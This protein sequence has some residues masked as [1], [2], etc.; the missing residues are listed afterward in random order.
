MYQRR[1]EELLC[2][3]IGSGPPDARECAKLVIVLGLALG[4][5]PIQQHKTTSLICRH[6]TFPAVRIFGQSCVLTATELSIMEPGD[7]TNLLQRQK[8]VLRAAERSKGQKATNKPTRLGLQLMFRQV[9][10][11]FL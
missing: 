2:Q 8:N 11:P 1:W 6:K 4:Q 3:V 9:M 10:L 5:A 7:Y